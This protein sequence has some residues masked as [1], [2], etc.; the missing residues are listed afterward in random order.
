MLLP[1]RPVD[2]WDFDK[3]HTFQ[4]YVVIETNY[5]GD[6]KPMQQLNVLVKDV[7]N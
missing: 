7:D 5:L 2:L 3:F 6:I 4:F 1:A